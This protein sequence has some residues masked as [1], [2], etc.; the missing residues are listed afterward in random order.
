VFKTLGKYLPPPAGAKSPALWGTP[1]RLSEMFGAASASISCEP[2]HFTFR[3]RSPAH[4]MEIFTTYYGPVLKAFAA[5]DSANQEA[6]R[7]DLLGLISR[8][9]RAEDGTLVVPGEYLEVVIVKR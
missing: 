3:Y 5:L 6:L 9:N 4:F 8:F 7:N 2:R 1:A